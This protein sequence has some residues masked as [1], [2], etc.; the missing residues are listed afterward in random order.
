MYTTYGD[1]P[2]LVMQLWPPDVWRRTEGRLSTTLASATQQ[3]RSFKWIDPSE[4]WWR[5]ERCTLQTVDKQEG[6]MVTRYRH[7][8]VS[9]PM[10]GSNKCDVSC[11][12]GGRE[13]PDAMSLR[14]EGTSLL[15]LLGR[16]CL[17]YAVMSM[18]NTAKYACV[19]Q[20]VFLY[21]CFKFK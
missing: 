4:W 11:L 15:D 12:Q 7:L 5:E 3:E 1:T 16:P 17:S 6:S 18:R 20:K 10:T 8:G 19:I 21:L 9:N 2:V 14:S 13:P